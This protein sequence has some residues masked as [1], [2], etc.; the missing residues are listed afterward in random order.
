MLMG[1]SAQ[2]EPLFCIFTLLFTI[3]FV[4]KKYFITSIYLTILVLLR[5]EAWVIPFVIIFIA[6]V[7]LFFK[8]FEVFKTD[9]SLWKPVFSIALPVMAMI[10]WVIARKESEGVWFGFIY[11]TKVFANDVL[12]STS[13]FDSGILQF[14]YDV[15]YYPIIVPYFLAGPVVIIALFGIKR[16]IKKTNPFFCL[17]Y[18]AILLFLTITWINKSSLGLHRHFMVM[19]PFY[20]ILLVNGIPFFSK[21]FL[22]LVSKVKRLKI[23]DEV[24]ENRLTVIKKYVSLILIA[25]QVIVT[26][27]WIAGWLGYSSNLF[28]ERFQTADFIKSLPPDK[29]IF[30]DEAAVE[31]LSGLDMKRFNRKWLEN[32]DAFELIVNTVKEKGEIY[33]VTWEKKINLYRSLGETIF[34]SSSDYNTKQKLQVLKITK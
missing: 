26:S 23:F 27:I 33:V 18:A 5:Y 24:R 16:T 19:V 8:K 2:P 14:I 6:I 1:T 3:S 12:K 30:C 31:V 7:K 20:S 9:K 29:I 15:F 21:V 28:T 13:S 11:G 32:E 10:I 17:V 25:S 34:T 22:K 4:K